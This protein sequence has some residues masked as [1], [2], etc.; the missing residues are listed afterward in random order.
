M[1]R[2]EKIGLVDVHSDDGLLAVAFYHGA[3]FNLNERKHLFSMINDLPTVRKPPK[4]KTNSDN[5]GSK[6][7]PSGKRMDVVGFLSIHLSF[8][9]YVAPIIFEGT[10]SI[11]KDT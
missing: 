2:K 9:I 4:E 10:S 6:S 3:W 11:T 8:R 5:S 1:A 7:K